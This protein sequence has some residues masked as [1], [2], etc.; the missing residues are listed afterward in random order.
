MAVWLSGYSLS[1]LY[2]YCHIPSY[3]NPNITATVKAN[4]NSNF[5]N[6]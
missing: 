2:M 4:P 6:N 5:T 1:G 3:G